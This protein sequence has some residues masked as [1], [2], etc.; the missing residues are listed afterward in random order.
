MEQDTVIGDITVTPFSVPHDAAEPCQFKFGHAGYS[1]GLLTD[2]GMITPHIVTML[3]GIDALLLECNHDVEMLAQSEYPA[4]LKVRVGSD[5]G[6]LNN[7][8]A[9]SLLQQMDTDNLKCIVAMH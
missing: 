4:T 2:T 9:V 8:Q 6:H 3:S 1:L 7:G 5:Y